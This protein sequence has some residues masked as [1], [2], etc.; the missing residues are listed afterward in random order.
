MVSQNTKS[1]QLKL[2]L[3]V[4][5]SNSGKTSWAE[6]L[7]KSQPNTIN[8][9]R[10]GFRFGKYAD[11]DL[12]ADM[13]NR[14]ITWSVFR[15][16]YDAVQEGK[17]IIISD[18]NLNWRSRVYWERLAQEHNLKLEYAIFQSAFNDIFNSKD[19]YKL[20][21][22][23]LTKQHSRYVDFVNSPTNPNANYLVI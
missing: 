20:P 18:S 6:D 10:D 14:E 5:L 4:G 12:P 19:V 21:K 9:S 1:K 23:V 11:S 7:C 16:F 2:I 22:H 17:N 8:I 3:T 15:E 13:L